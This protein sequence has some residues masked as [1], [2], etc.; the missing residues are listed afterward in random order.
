MSLGNVPLSRGACVALHG[1]PGGSG[2]RRT[3]WSQR[4]GPG[5]GTDLGH[6]WAVEIYLLPQ[7]PA[8]GIFLSLSK[9]SLLNDTCYWQ[10]TPPVLSPALATERIQGAVER[11]PLHMPAEVEDAQQED[12]I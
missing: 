10:I 12:E 11:S 8:L 4:G 2:Y 9:R 7:T 3:P 1:G 6:L 5:A